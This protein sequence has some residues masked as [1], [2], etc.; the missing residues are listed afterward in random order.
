[1]EECYKSQASTC[2]FI[3]KVTLLHGCFSR[4]L[5][6]TNGAKSQ[7]ASHITSQC[8][9][10]ASLTMNGVRSHLHA[11]THVYFQLGVQ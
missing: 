4:F 1:M 2:N 10:A 7:K 8:K 9:P 11:P 5:N 6:C 3:L